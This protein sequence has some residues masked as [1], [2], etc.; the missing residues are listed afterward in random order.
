MSKYVKCTSWGARAA[1]PSFFER[2]SAQA[3]HPNQ[4]AAGQVV[5]CSDQEF[6]TDS[7]KL[8]YVFFFG[9]GNSK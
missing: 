6:L 9:G 4:L 1:G 7:E 8:F 3:R 5:Q 2:I